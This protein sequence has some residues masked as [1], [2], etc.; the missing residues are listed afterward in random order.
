MYELIVYYRVNI[1]RCTCFVIRV[2][3]ERRGGSQRIFFSMSTTSALESLGRCKFPHNTPGARG[4]ED[5]LDTLCRS[6]P[7]WPLG[8]LTV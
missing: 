6:A 3:E 4:R 7:N 8:F 2:A 1:T 5:G